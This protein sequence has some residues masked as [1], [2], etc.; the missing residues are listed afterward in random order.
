MKCHY[1]IP[2]PE[3]D[4]ILEDLTREEYAKIQNGDFPEED[5]ERK[6][7]FNITK[8]KSEIREALKCD[9][10]LLTEEQRLKMFV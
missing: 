1:S 5:I 9:N 7:T 4:F 3:E 6:L 2:F 10:N 8:R